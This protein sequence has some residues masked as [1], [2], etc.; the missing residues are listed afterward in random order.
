MIR[1]TVAAAIALLALTG[2]S[3]SPSTNSVFPLTVGNVWNTQ[4]YLLEGQPTAPLDT[5]ETGTTI[6][7]AVEKDNLTNGKEVIK[8]QTV[9][10]VYVHSNSSADT[11]T[12]SSYLRE[13][14]NAILSYTALDDTVGDTVM[15][16]DPE[17]GQTW[18]QG[19]ATAVVVGLEDVTVAAGTYK[20]AWKVKRT[21]S[22]GGDTVATFSWYANGV[23]NVKTHSESEYQG[24]SQV[25]DEELTSATIK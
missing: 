11:T 14:N 19:P 4:F 18:N 13:E 2:T 15:V 9:S 10:T 16:L 17:V 23:G 7:S 12:D 6:S 1:V 21:T 5:Y 8:L 24:S 22:I 25:Y 3:C 20:Q